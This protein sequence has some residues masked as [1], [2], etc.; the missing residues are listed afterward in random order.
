MSL[1]PRFQDVIRPLCERI[2]ISTPD[3]SRRSVVLAV[4]E[5]LTVDLLGD[6]DGFLVLL[7]EIHA[8]VDARDARRLLPL[9]A[10]NRFAAEHP[11]LIGS[12]EPDSGRFS[13]WTRERLSELDEPA[14]FALFD[15]LL[16]AASSVRDWLQAPLES[17][18]MPLATV[19][20]A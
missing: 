1:H 18:P 7:A 5:G 17:E 9:L 16:S 12:V 19:P 3:A 4:D 13:L 11:A 20:L 15:R 14:L 8:S 6:Q 2:G 10:A